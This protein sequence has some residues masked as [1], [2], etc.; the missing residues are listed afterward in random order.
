MM[1]TYLHVRLR[2]PYGI[3]ADKQYLSVSLSDTLPFKHN[4]KNLKVK[5]YIST[6]YLYFFGGVFVNDA[7][8]N[9]SQATISLKPQ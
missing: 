2:I 8:K 6:I 5:A 7:Q 1:I 3:N 4:N 9:G